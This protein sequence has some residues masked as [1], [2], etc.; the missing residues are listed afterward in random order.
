MKEI[1]WISVGVESKQCTS[2]LQKRETHIHI[3]ML[4]IFNHIDC[5]EANNNAT[6]MLKIDVCF[7]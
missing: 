2:N 7:M 6:F 4:I 3:H 1:F 5:N